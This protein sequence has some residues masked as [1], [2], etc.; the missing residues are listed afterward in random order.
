LRASYARVRITVENRDYHYLSQ[1]E[2][3]GGKSISTAWFD[4]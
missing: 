4:I 2:M 3:G 1:C